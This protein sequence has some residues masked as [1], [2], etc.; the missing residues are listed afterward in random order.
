MYV[1][2]TK[3]M[4]HYSVSMPFKIE[5][6]NNYEMDLNSNYCMYVDYHIQYKDNHEISPWGLP[7]SGDKPKLKQKLTWHTLII[8]WN[9]Q[10][11]ADNG[12]NRSKEYS[13]KSWHIS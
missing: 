12:V 4:W 6:Y 13:K 8:P 10:I 9:N 1:G 2:C 11:K 5:L 7:N 3:H